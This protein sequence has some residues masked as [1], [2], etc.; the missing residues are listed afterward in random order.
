[1]EPGSSISLLKD[2]FNCSIVS[3]TYDSTQTVNLTYK[4]F[5]Y[6]LPTDGQINATAV[7]A[8]YTPA[9]IKTQYL[10]FPPDLA[11]YKLTNDNFSYH[12]NVLSG[13]IAPAHGEI[14]T[15]IEIDDNA[16]IIA[17]KIRAYL[18]WNFDSPFM[19]ADFLSNYQSAPDGIDTVEWF[20]E[21]DGG[22]WSDFATAFCIFT[23]AL[24]V[25]SRFVDGFHSIGVEEIV[26]IEGP[27][28]PIK[29]Q[30]MYNWAEIYIP[31]DVSGNG[32]WIQMDIFDS[33]SVSQAI[34]PNNFTYSLEVSSNPS[35]PI[36]KF[37]SA[38][39]SAT[40]S[41]VK[42]SFDGKTITF[43]DVTE[44]NEIL[45]TA[46]TDVNGIASFIVNTDSTTVAGPHTIL[47]YYNLNTYNTT[48]IFINGDIRVNLTS[49]N[50]TFINLSVSSDLTLQGFV[51]DYDNGKQIDNA[52]VSFVMFLN[53]TNVNVTSAAFMNPF[54]LT[55]T[56]NG[57]TFTHFFLLR[58]TLGIGDY[59][60]RTDF[61]GTFFGSGAFPYLN[62]SSQR[63]YINVTKGVVKNLTL[64]LDNIAPNNPNIPIKVR[65][66]TLQMKA[67]VLNQTG[68]AVINEAIEFYNSSGYIGQ[69][70]T[71][72][73]GEAYFNL[74]IGAS[75]KSGPNLVYA[76]L[77]SKNNYS[78]YILNELAKI[79]IAS[80]PTPLEINRTTPGI[81]IFSINGNITDLVNYS[82]PISYARINFKLLK[83][84][85][86]YT[87]SLTG[88]NPY[89]FQVGANG[90][91]SV[92]FG[93]ASNTPLGNYTLRV[94]F[95]GSINFLGN[96]NYPYD[97]TLPILTTSTTLN[98]ELKVNDLGTLIFNFLING[99]TNDYYNN[100][101][102]NRNGSVFLSIYLQR[103]IDVFI[104]ESVEFYDLTQ[105]V[106]IGSSI[107]D[108]FGNA[109]LT[110]NPTLATIA[111]PHL[112]YAKYG[113]NYNYSYF[114][115]D[116]PID[117]TLDKC[118]DPLEINRSGPNGR[119]FNIHGY[120]NDTLNGIN[121]KYCR[122]SVFLFD[123]LIDVS[124]RLTV[125]SGSLQCGNTGEIDV[126]Y[127]VDTA[128]ET[129]NYSIQVWFNGTFL[130]DNPYDVDNPHNYFLTSFNNFSYVANGFNELRILD[131][132]NVRILLNVDGNPALP[133]Y[134][135]V[136]PPECYN[137]GETI[138]FQVQ[139]NQSGLYAP[140]N[141]TVYLYDLDNYSFSSSYQ[142]LLGNDG[143][144]VFSVDTTGWH[145][146][147]HQIKVN[148]STFESSN[149]TYIIINETVS[150]SAL[151]SKVTVIRDIESFTISGT[152]SEN[153][154]N[155]RGLRV[156]IVLF[157]KNFN[158]VSS[159]L[160]I[161]SHTTT[162]SSDGSYQFLVTSVNIDNYIGECYVRIDFNGSISAPGIFL[163]DYMK[164][165]NSSLIHLNVSADTELING[166]YGTE[167][168]HDEWNEGD[169]LYVNGTLRWDNGTG[170]ANMNIAIQVSDGATILS[171]S[172][173]LTDP[174]GD[175]SV[176]IDVGDWD[177]TTEV[178]FYYYPKEPSNFGIP[179]GYYVEEIIGEQI[180]GTPT[181]P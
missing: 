14:V 6:N 111:G 116:A 104:G 57:G 149:A 62:D 45:G 89:D 166:I 148:W 175:F 180:N 83:S 147:L 119:N 131:P 130:Y 121:P 8:N 1:V 96:P 114:I 32:Q 120:I 179:D 177:L 74:S 64:F 164:H 173:G 98:K 13:A 165:A 65:G 59:E 94:D 141:T 127:R 60:I 154:A 69:D 2:N 144:H 78:Y 132:D 50:P 107:T 92:T 151:S 93:V 140:D 39:I 143:Y 124:W 85:T 56:A 37:D 139:V 86:D 61:N 103:G 17:D 106:S 75:S 102:I 170:I 48:Q 153:G 163:S 87:A 58:D 43:V 161:G 23:R 26:D 176:Q 76:K 115:L 88:D 33:F 125:D 66:T 16:F 20:L 3:I 49:V 41:S 15:P 138:N 108:A 105:D 159:W 117:I 90:S 42:G 77:G 72:I 110:Y 25:A 168:I 174:S 137:V 53:G 100:P 63:I 123:G 68:G 150:I 109:I 29:Y 27:C 73:N 135:D 136:N 152:I 55:I 122:I 162:I 40:L 51:Y 156:T 79:H 22:M 129:K 4:L 31:E 28:F 113:S 24:G 181:P 146:G 133:H 99:F 80:G 155:L 21:Q 82:M 128:T 52:V 34:D 9:A 118:P 157:D 18:Q 84:G 11:S 126:T 158:N 142:F 36:D 178:F 7:Y 38:N 172:Y 97:F 91:F 5:G 70:T 46:V 12:L 145:A 67:V 160:N 44:D 54:P 81:T 167:Y 71:D 19:G 101:V 171:I 35:S 10:S 47:A 95:N 134:N 30:N 169:I 112:I